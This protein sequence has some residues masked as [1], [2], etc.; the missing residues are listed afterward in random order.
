MAKTKKAD[1]HEPAN[2]TATNPVSERALV[3]RINTRFG[4]ATQGPATLPQ[5][6]PRL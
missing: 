2:M 1:R 6:H 3:A 4:E 5:R